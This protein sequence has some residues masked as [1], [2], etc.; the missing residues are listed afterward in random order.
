MSRFPQLTDALIVDVREPHEFAAGHIPRAIN[1]PL[2][3]MRDR[4]VEL[5]MDREIWVSCGVGQRA[6]F[7]TRFLNQ[8]GYPVRNLSG[9]FATHTAFDNVRSAT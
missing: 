1:L 7:A 9:G 6:Y 2:S 8:H 4:Y 5:P 3:E